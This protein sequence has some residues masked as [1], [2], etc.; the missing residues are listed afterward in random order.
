MEN[1]A[2]VS[3]GTDMVCSSCVCVC[4]CVCVWGAGIVCV[5]GGGGGGMG[6]WGLVVGGLE[7]GGTQQSGGLLRFTS[8]TYSAPYTA[9]SGVLSDV[10]AYLIMPEACQFV[11]GPGIQPAF[12]VNPHL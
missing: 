7:G 6:V 8:L 3:I 1:G 12:S 10:G 11:R 5:C 2:E 9:Y 4:V